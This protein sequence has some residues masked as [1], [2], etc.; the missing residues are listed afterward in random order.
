MSGKAI[1]MSLVRIVLLTLAMLVLFLIFLGIAQAQTAAKESEAQSEQ[2]RTAGLDYAEFMEYWLIF[3][4]II[5]EASQKEKI[6]I[7]YPKAIRELEDFIK[8]NPNSHWAIEAKMRIAELKEQIFYEKL[9]KEIETGR[10]ELKKVELKHSPKRIKCVEIRRR[11]DGSETK[12]SYD[13]FAWK[14]VALKVFNLETGGAMII[15]AKK[16]GQGVRSLQPEFIITIEPR[17]S[18]IIWNGRNTAYK[19]AGINGSKWVVILNKFPNRLKNGKRRDSIYSSHS[20]ALARKIIAENGNKY[21]SGQILFALFELG[22]LMAEVDYKLEIVEKASGTLVTGA[23]E[24]LAL[25]EHSDYF[26]VAEFK[27]GRWPHN[28]FERVLAILALNGPEAYSSTGSPAQAKGLMQATNRWRGQRPGTWDTIRQTYPWAKLPSFE[29]G[30]AGHRQSIK[31]AIL[32][33]N[34][35][36]GKLLE[37]FG[38]EIIKDPELEYY[39]AAAY[40]GGHKHVIEAIQN[41]KKRGTNWRD[42]LRKLKKTTE[43]LD[44][45]DKLDYLLNQSK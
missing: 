27:A 23:I 38:E 18:G 2:V 39:L 42:E 4:Q 44:Y 16:V 12:H 30:P 11:S 3:N 17:P 43:N 28:P 10:E 35:N 37:V 15:K 8:R 32:L 20:T 13:D 6:E 29:T 9:V 45:L 40:N 24:R 41:S 25:M 26:E 1:R 36:F 31:F 5:G 21:L 22:R 19:V 33:Q 34:F 7:I 14:E